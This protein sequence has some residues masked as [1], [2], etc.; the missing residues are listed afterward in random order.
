[1]KVSLESASR[2]PA[3]AAGS[4]I[5]A[6]KQGPSGLQLFGRLLRHARPFWFHLVCLVV[7]SA[8]AAP[9]A[10]L[11][12][13][14][15]KVVVDSVIRPYPLP[16]FVGA[17]LPASATSSPS[18]LL[19]VATVLLLLVTL[20][21][22]V[23]GTITWLLSSY[24][25]ERLV[26]NLRAALFARAQRLSLAYHDS[27]GTMDSLYRIQ[28]DALA[29]QWVLIESAIPLLTAAITLVGL[30]VVSVNIDWQLALL[31]LGVS[32][33]LFLLTR[34]FS[35]ALRQKW[36][37][38]KE[39]D[40]S[41]ISV[42]QESLSGLRVVKA[43]GREAHETTRFVDRT[44]QKV[45]GQ[46]DVALAQS[47]FDFVVGMT[48]VVGTAAVLF[49]GANHVLNG[50]LTL[51]NLLVVLAYTSQLLEPLKTMSNTVVNLQ[52]GLGSAE[53]ALSL[54]DRPDEVTEKV[55]ARA[56]TRARGHV[57]FDDVT[58]AY[59][60]DRPVLRGISFDV[61]AGARVGV[62]GRTG[63]GK[64]TLM[65]L[66][67]RFYDPVAGRILVDDMDIR[68]YK[69]A[70]LRNQFAVVLQEPILLSATI[71]ENI[72]YARPGAFQRDIE[73][74]AR[75]AHAHEFIRALPDGYGTLVGERGMKLSGGERQRIGLA[76]AFLK[77]APILILDEPTSS[78]D[79][80]TEALIVAAM[81]RLTHGRTTFIVAHR[82]STLEAC[83][84]RLEIEAGRVLSVRTCASS[85][86]AG[87]TDDVSEIEDGHARGVKPKEGAC[88]LSY[89]G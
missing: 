25:A 70:D 17:V 38:V 68:D 45:R 30:V 56:F 43:F 61:A 57:A 32:P 20:V 33:V 55:D 47:K 48:V 75:L 2:P 84:V 36:I 29:M 44:N 82:L 13:V 34:H 54:L 3:G 58:F 69:L 39:I 24:T 89:S 67:M 65:S 16:W 64:T 53:R 18:R 80:K 77:D 11:T 1:M 31:T 76:R 50:T 12:P 81:E 9:F 14:P 85:R 37:A 42:V 7:L 19:V 21:A 71:G 8:L 22:H 40:T 23:R 60:R 73:E 51:G 88:G 87:T 63:S 52:D 10:L 86:K 49:V 6:A 41:A 26:A 46:L 78:V 74:A 35:P 4:R 79:V 66:L 83:D 59:E 28:Y 72:A 62:T 15:L 5:H 27:T